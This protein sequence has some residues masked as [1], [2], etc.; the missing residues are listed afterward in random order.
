MIYYGGPT[1]GWQNTSLDELPKDLEIF[2]TFEEIQGNCPA[3][4]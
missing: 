1:V 4:V 2:A 3:V